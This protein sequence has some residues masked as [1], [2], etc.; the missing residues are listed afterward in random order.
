MKLLFDVL[1][2]REARRQPEVS[3]LA[4]A[5]A[6]QQ[7]PE[8]RLQASSARDL[9][10]MRAAEERELTTYGWIDEAAGVVRIPIER[11]MDLVAMEGLPAAAGR[12]AAGEAGA[13]APEAE[14]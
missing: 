12:P 6:P 3:P 11:A 7:P 4:A 1:A 2:A 5:L 14:P 8:P 13:R 9:L 10:E